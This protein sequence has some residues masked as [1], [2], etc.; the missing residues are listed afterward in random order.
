MNSSASVKNPSQRAIAGS[1]H[2]S[3]RLLKMIIGLSANRG[4][5][6]KSSMPEKPLSVNGGAKV[7]RAAVK[8]YDTRL[9]N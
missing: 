1:H 2:L 5:P 9:I 3:V 4:F 8:Y 7:K 6:L